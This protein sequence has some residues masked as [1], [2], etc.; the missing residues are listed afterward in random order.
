LNL[1]KLLEKHR[2]RRGTLSTQIRKSIFAVFRNLPRINLKASPSEIKTWKELPVVK[3]CYEKLHRDTPEDETITW[4]GKI[5]Q[6]TWPDAKKIPNEQIAFA[7]AL[8]ESFLNPDNEIIKNDSKYLS[9][10]IQKNKVSIKN[11]RN[12]IISNILIIYIIYINRKKW[13][14]A[15]NSI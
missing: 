6:E 1:L 10:R 7:V 14:K 13:R 15:K 11:I 12:F 9:K 5:I 8:C 4:C 3:E 2:S